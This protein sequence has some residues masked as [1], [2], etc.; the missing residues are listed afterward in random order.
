MEDSVFLHESFLFLLKGN[1]V[2]KSVSRVRNSGCY[3]SERGAFSVPRWESFVWEPY[4]ESLSL[5][6][7]L[8]V[9]WMW[10]RRKG[11]GKSEVWCWDEDSREGRGIGDSILAAIKLKHRWIRGG[12]K[13]DS[14]FWSI[15]LRSSLILC[16]LFLQ[17]KGP[18]VPLAPFWRRLK[19]KRLLVVKLGKNLRTWRPGA[20][21]NS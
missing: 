9:N 14:V 2:C 18:S 6:Q 4:T 15:A 20:T 10:L 11:C 12:L 16:L 21:R 19:C 13:H 1:L 3:R 17:R 7:F 8:F 5:K